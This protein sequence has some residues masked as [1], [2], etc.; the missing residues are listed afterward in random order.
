MSD[1]PSTASHPNE[2]LPADLAAVQ[3]TLLRDGK[4]WRQQIAVPA[5]LEEYVATRVPRQAA[6][7]ISPTQGYLPMATRTTEARTGTSAPRRSRTTYPIVAVVLLL[8]L[9]GGFF[10]LRALRPSG[11]TGPG[12]VGTSSTIRRTPTVAPSNQWFSLTQVV[13]T[14]GAPTPLESFVIGNDEVKPQHLVAQ[15]YAD[16]QKVHK[17]DTLTLVW[18]L[19]GVILTG[20]QCCHFQLSPMQNS[21]G[22]MVPVTT[23]GTGSVT[24]SY[25]TTLAFTATFTVVA[26]TTPPT[27]PATPTVMPSQ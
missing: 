19:N 4:V 11:T 27:I 6:S 26:T 14:K 15:T 18:K 22:F 13:Y 20:P 10:S 16:P 5:R 12:N 3:H 21:T 7:P 24:I 8:V 25:N 23:S 17:G 9:V 1:E 2:A